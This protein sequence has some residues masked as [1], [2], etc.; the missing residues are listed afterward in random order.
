MQVDIS[1][2]RTWLTPAA[3]INHGNPFMRIPQLRLILIP[4]A[5]SRLWPA[6]CIEKHLLTDL[7][8]T[9]RLLLNWISTLDSMYGRVIRMM[10]LR[11]VLL[12]K[13][14]RCKRSLK[15]TLSSLGL[16]TQ[17]LLFQ[18]SS[19]LLSSDLLWVPW[20]FGFGFGGWVGKISV[21]ILLTVI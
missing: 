20:R 1:P 19:A 14:L 16:S 7:K 13:S 12:V 6:P 4:M 10:K 15:Q 11:Q 9:W 17:L 18:H 21:E 3:R 2:S 8:S 5:A